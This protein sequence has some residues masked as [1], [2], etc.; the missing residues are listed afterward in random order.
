[1]SVGLALFIIGIAGMILMW[2]HMNGDF[3]S[4][5]DTDGEIEEEV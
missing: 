1:M 4:P 3:D 2:Q 5:E